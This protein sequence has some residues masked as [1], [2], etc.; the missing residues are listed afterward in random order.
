MSK[1][2]GGGGAGVVQTRAGRLR[3][4]TSEISAG[5]QVSAMKNGKEIGYVIYN[6]RDGE[7]KVDTVHVDPEHRRKGVATAL[8]DRVRKKEGN[9]PFARG[10]QL[11]EGQK[12]RE[13]YDRG[14]KK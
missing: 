8:Y 3:I 12:F 14:K 1:G 10:P 6:V 9:K 2:S 13:S 11:E 5:T 4:E 7:I